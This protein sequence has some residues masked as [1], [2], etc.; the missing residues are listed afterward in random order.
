[1][2]VYW[3]NRGSGAGRENVIFEGDP[4]APDNK[5]KLEERQL[6]IF[7]RGAAAGLGPESAI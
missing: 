4:L 3:F 2:P 5:T 6:E 1:V 7:R